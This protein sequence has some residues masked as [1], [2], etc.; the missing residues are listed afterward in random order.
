M[1]KNRTPRPRFASVEVIKVFD[2]PDDPQ[3]GEF[4]FTWKGTAY[5]PGSKSAKWVEVSPVVKYDS[6]KTAFRCGREAMERF[7]YEVIASA[8]GK[9][10]N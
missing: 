4:R 3:P 10:I 5:K 8:S 7:G 9:W 6:A 1:K 2:N